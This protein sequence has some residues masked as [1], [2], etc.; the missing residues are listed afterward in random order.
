MLASSKPTGIN[1]ARL[2]IL[3]RYFGSLLQPNPIAVK[4]AGL[5]GA[6]VGMGA[7]IIALGLQQIRRQVGRAVAVEIGQGR[8]ERRR[9]NAQLDGRF[10]HVP[11]CRLGLFH[12]LREIRSQKQVFQLRIGVERFLDAFQKHRADDASAAPQERDRPELQRPLVLDGRGLHLHVALGVAANLRG[13]KR[14]ADVLDE[15]LAIARV[16]ARRAV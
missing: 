16:L 7:E 12:G 3:R 5:I 10:D 2:A 14:L 13:V 6:I 8:G 15:F 11:P 4:N 1:P 9:G